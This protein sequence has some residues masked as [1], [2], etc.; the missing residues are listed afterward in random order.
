MHVER[1]PELELSRRVRLDRVPPGGISLDI[2]AEDAERGALARRF[3]AIAVPA[4]TAAVTLRS[5]ATGQWR[6]DG[7]LRAVVVQACG[8]TLE[9]IEQQVEDTFTLHFAAEAEAIDRDSGELIVGA[10]APEP[11]EDDTLDLGAI[12]A[13][14]FGLALDPF[15]RLPGARLEDVL[16]ASAGPSPAEGPFAAL[17]ALKKGRKDQI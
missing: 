7:Q 13:D 11:L 12:V 8:I 2:V 9:P 14:Q 16:P 1:D 17:A 5:E 4:L 10:D 3:D 6:V 15:P